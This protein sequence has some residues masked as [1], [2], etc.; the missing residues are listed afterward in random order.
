MGKVLTTY[1]RKKEAVE[2]PVGVVLIE[3]PRQL[4]KKLETPCTHPGP[5][6]AYLLAQWSPLGLYRDYAFCC[7]S[8]KGTPPTEKL[9]S[10]RLIQDLTAFSGTEE[11]IWCIPHK[12]LVDT[13]PHLNDT[14]QQGHPQ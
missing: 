6:H 3:S 14:H 4:A 2:A 1:A 9:D 12:W 13:K 8:Q 10:N 7:L 11:G 5:N